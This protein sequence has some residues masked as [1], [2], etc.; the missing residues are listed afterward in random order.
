[1]R[2]SK[3]KDTLIYNAVN[4]DGEMGDAQIRGSNVSPP[5]LTGQYELGNDRNAAL[6]ALCRDKSALVELPSRS[7]SVALLAVY[8]INRLCFFFKQA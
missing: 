1:M 3:D 2:V 7:I 5:W 6:M 8:N 4:R